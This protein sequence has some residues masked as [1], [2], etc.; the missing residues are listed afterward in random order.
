MMRMQ[1][2]VLTDFLPK[3]DGSTFPRALLTT[4]YWSL[5]KLYSGRTSK[6]QG[7]RKIAKPK[8]EAWRRH[9]CHVLK[10]SWFLDVSLDWS[11]QSFVE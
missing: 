4:V 7:A 1:R 6:P 5:G 11:C 8:G 9:P 10:L 3:I 2:R